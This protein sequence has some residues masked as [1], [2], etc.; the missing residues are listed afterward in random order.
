[1]EHLNSLFGIFFV[2]HFDERK[3]ARAAG[4]T[5]LHYVNRHYDAG[6]REMILQVVFRRG[7]GE[8]SHE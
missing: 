5:V 4:H 7:E 1:V 8:V 2:G 6:L 3:T